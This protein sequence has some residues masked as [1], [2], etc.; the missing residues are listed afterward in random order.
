M[1]GK[2]I[3]AKEVCAAVVQTAYKESKNGFFSV[4][5]ADA[6]LRTINGA[7]VRNAAKAGT[8]FRNAFLETEPKEKKEAVLDLE[9]PLFGIGNAFLH[10]AIFDVRRNV[11]TEHAVQSYLR[12]AKLAYWKH[13]RLQ[14]D[15]EVALHN[16]SIAEDFTGKRLLLEERLRLVGFMLIYLAGIFI[17]AI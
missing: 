12:I 9:K 11:L 6:S 13:L 8:Y 16:L 3:I 14:P 10:K 4:L 2:G 15:D 7:S 17:S 1:P 5:F